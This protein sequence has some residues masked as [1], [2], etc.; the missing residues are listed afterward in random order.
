MTRYL[1]VLTIPCVARRASHTK[2]LKGVI[3]IVSEQ[4]WISYQVYRFSIRAN[5][6]RFYSIKRKLS[7][8]ISCPELDE[9]TL[10]TFHLGKK[11]FTCAILKTSIFRYLHL[12]TYV[13]VDQISYTGKSDA[14]DRG[15]YNDLERVTTRV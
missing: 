6:L 2:E 8:V 7:R 3:C 11:K 12:C 14:L 13:L 15:N 10:L 1:Q 5:L 9:C 4:N